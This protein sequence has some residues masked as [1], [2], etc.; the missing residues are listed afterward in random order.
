MK[1]K[2]KLIYIPIILSIIFC[3]FMLGIT[4]YIT[5]GFSFKNLSKADFWIGLILT[6]LGNISIILAI[7][8]IN[9]DSYKSK[10]EEYIGMQTE[11]HTFRKT[12]YIAP[13]F[14][15]FCNEINKKTKIIYYKNKI[16]KKYSKLKPKPKD[17]NIYNSGSDTEKLNNKYCQKVEYYNY[18]LSDKYIN[19][20]I[21]KIKMKYPIVSASLIFSGY[22]DDLSLVDYI[23][24]HK[25][26]K[27]ILDFLPKFLISFSI[28]V[29]LA[30][31]V[32]SLKDNISIATVLNTLARLF[33]VCIQIYFA[34]DYS[35]RYNNEV[36][37]HDI[38]FRVSKINE[39][40]VWED[41]QKSMLKN[42]ETKEISNN[43]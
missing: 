10:D 17:L 16:E 11:I 7:I 32:P 12:K 39:Y 19:E 2:I 14:V 38:Q 21:D 22:R 25:A 29:L 41:R 27:V 15:K 37:F 30:S 36:T 40:I 13:L 3:I 20:N 42:N 24:K 34:K 28:T 26:K 8:L 5:A 23:T 18:L 31:M 33:A 43:G 35:K 6:N 9:V 4:D 1:V